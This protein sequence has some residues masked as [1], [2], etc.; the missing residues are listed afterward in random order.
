MI[1]QIYSIQNIEEAQFCLDCGV[2]RIG[3]TAGVGSAQVPAAITLERGRKIF[4]HIGERAKKVAL[5]VAEDAE[6]I[7]PVISYLKPDIIHVCGNKFYATEDFAKNVKSRF[8]DVE[9]LQAIGVTAE[10]A[11]AQAEYYA[12]FCDYLILDSVKEGIDGIGVAGV[13]HDWSISREIVT[14][15]ER[16]NCRVILAGGLGADNVADAIRAVRPFGVDSFTKTSR[17]GRKD[18]ELIRAFVQNAQN[19]AREL[20]L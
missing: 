18:C 1:T 15:L 12:R 9:I 3:I 2:D 19:A 13:T 11:I 10:A 4:E 17:N 14:R 8:P 20:G 7:Y 16:T 5:T 6:S